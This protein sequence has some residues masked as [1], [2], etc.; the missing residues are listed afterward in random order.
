[1]LSFWCWREQGEEGF[2][3]RLAFGMSTRIIWTRREWTVFEGVAEPG[4]DDGLVTAYCEP[5]RQKRMARDAEKEKAPIRRLEKGS[6]DGG[7]GVIPFSSAS[8]T[9]LF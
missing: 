2:G 7:K 8:E 5:R 3:R 1:M 6:D 4:L 9:L